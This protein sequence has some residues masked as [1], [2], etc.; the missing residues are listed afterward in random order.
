MKVLIRMSEEKFIDEF[1]KLDNFT[2]A[3]LKMFYKHVKAE[4]EGEIFKEP[5]AELQRIQ[6]GG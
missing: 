3:G 4:Y 6:N 5:V 2:L 1:K